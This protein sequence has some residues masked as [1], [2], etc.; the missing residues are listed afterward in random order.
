MARGNIQGAR[1]L[2]LV[3]RSE[4]EFAMLTYAQ[5]LAEDTL[6]GYLGWSSLADH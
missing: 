1:R 3:A 2:L 5:H 6:L 4:L